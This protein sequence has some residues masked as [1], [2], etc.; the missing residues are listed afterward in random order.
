MIIACYRLQGSQVMASWIVVQSFIKKRCE[1]RAG[2]G[3][4]GERNHPTIP[5]SRASY[6]RFVPFKY[7]P[8]ILSEPLA[9]ASVHD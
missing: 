8:T 5:R 7:V 1:K 3:G 9:Q 6:F 4:A 2:G